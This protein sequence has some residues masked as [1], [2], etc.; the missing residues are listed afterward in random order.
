MKEN[1][2]G[3]PIFIYRNTFTPFSTYRKHG[4]EI[5]TYK[6]YIFKTPLEWY[7]CRAHLLKGSQDG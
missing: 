6:I 4:F 3:V 5:D 2:V 1:N 7:W